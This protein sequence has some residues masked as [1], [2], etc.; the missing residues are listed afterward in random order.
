MALPELRGLYAITPDTPDTASLIDRVEAALKGGCRWVQ[1]RDKLST[2]ETRISRAHALATLCRLHNAGLIINDDVDLAIAVDAAGVHIGRDDGDIASARRRIG[3]KKLIGVS[4]YADFDAASAAA[5]AG[6]GYIAF[7]AVFAS[8]T[9]PEAVTAP[10]ELFAR[11][12][13]QLTVPAC[14]IGGITLDNATLAIDA[15]ARLLAVITDLFSAPDIAQ[16]AAAY[17][18]LFEEPAV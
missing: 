6:A 11:A 16:R 12:R 14:A 18:R 9:K 10:L 17:Q 4:C 5:D 13:E 8:P 3:D 2:R 15:G 1:Y 7:G